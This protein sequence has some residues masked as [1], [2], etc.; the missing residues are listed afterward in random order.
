M[1]IVQLCPKVGPNATNGIATHVEQL[2]KGLQ[3]YGDHVDIFGYE[4]VTNPGNRT[5]RHRIEMGMGQ[6]HLFCPLR[7][8]SKMTMADELKTLNRQLAYDALEYFDSLDEQPHLVHCHDCRLVFA[9]TELCSALGVP[10]VN[11]MH[12]VTD[13]SAE[14]E[15]LQ[16]QSRLCAMSTMTIAVSLFVKDWAR[17][18]CG[19]SEQAIRVVYNGVDLSEVQRS[20]LSFEALAEAR[21]RFAMDDEKVIVYAGRLSPQKGVSALLRSA[22]VVLRKFPKV[23]YVVAGDVEANGYAPFLALFAN[24]HPYLKGR[25][26][27]IGRQTRQEMVGIFQLADIVVVP[28]LREAFGYS[29]AEAMSAGVPVI[30]T[31]VGGLPEVL[32]HGNCGLLV[33]IRGEGEAEDVD[34][35]RLAS[36]QL[37]LLRDGEYARKLGAAGRQRVE[38]HFGVARMIDA[39]RLIYSDSCDR[40]M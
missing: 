22:A 11:T 1:R 21:R 12:L 2:A 13:D 29:A 20:R 39:V 3:A 10:L 34:I 33:P 37:E 40:C 38:T 23:A 15:L 7:G 25:V 6:A 5:D 24:N 32:G 14:V 26:R 35:D 31:S 9:A 8:S 4:C 27:F 17:T 28:S 36:A 30:A 19:V 16:M 18:S